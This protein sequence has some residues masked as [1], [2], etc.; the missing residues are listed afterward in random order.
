MLHLSTPKISLQG[1]LKNAQYC[2]ENDAFYAEMIIHLTMQSRDTP[3]GTFDGA[4]KDTLS[5]LHKD[6]QEGVCEF[7]LKGALEV[8]LELRCTKRCN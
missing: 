3:E 2:K 1:A 7:A 5:D 4:P 6:A 8:A